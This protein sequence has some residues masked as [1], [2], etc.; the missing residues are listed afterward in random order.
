MATP[1]EWELWLGLSDQSYLTWKSQTNRTKSTFEI[2]CIGEEYSLFS[3]STDYVKDARP[4]DQSRSNQDRDQ[5][6]PV[7]SHESISPIKV[8]PSPKR[9]FHA[10]IISRIIRS[11]CE[12]QITLCHVLPSSM[13]NHHVTKETRLHTLPFLLL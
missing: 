2:C 10:D 1:K 8:C 7:Q 6:K 3:H 4:G 9:H 11:I 13:Q 12:R 5:I